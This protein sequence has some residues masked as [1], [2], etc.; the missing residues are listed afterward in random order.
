MKIAMKTAAVVAMI[1]VLVSAVPAP[2]LADG[3]GDWIVEACRRDEAVVAAI[4]A[5]RARVRANKEEVEVVQLGK[6]CGFRGCA[7]RYL[8][9]MKEMRGGVNPQ[10]SS[11]LVVVDRGYKLPVKVTLSKLV[12]KEAE[13]TNK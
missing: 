11:V 5:A 1:S 9:I 8:V 10:A 12:P 3:G 7:I 13:E 4:N 6:T 2:S